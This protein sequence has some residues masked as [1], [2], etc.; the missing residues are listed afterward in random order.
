LSRVKAPQ[1]NEQKRLIFHYTI[2]LSLKISPPAGGKRSAIKEPEKKEFVIPRS[3]IPQPSD[4][5]EERQAKKRRVHAMKSQFRMEK[6]EEELSKQRN[7]WQKFAKKS[8]ITS[9]TSIFKYCKL[10]YLIA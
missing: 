1:K 3:L 4:T 9:R 6:Q 10:I 8:G 5:P 2:S 7:S